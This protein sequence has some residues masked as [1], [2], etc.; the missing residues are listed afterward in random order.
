M[1]KIKVPRSVGEATRLLRA[2]GY[3]PE[4]MGASRKHVHWRHPKLPL[5]PDL[6]TPKG[7]AKHSVSYKCGFDLK[8]I[9]EEARIQ[10]ALQTPAEED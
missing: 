7:G 3:K 1:A 9:L 4:P 5:A 6:I 10:I 8:R 2:A